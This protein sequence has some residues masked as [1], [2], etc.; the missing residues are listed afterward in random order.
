M[1]VHIPQ[2]CH[3]GILLNICC[4]AEVQQSGAVKPLL[5][6]VQQRSSSDHVQ[7]SCR[8]LTAVLADPAAREDFAKEQGV[9]AICQLLA[10]VGVSPGSICCHARRGLGAA[11]ASG[12]LGT[13]ATSKSLWSCVHDC[14]YPVT[15]PACMHPCVFIA[16]QCTI[17]STHTTQ[18]AY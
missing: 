11:T 6:C 9:E 12:L 3:A 4:Y 1:Q 14:Q 17:I 15:I 13:H 18:H 7:A 2:Q 10:T 8:L 5:Q 16:S